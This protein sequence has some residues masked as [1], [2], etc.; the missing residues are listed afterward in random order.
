MLILDYTVHSVIWR[1]WVKYLYQKYSRKHLL[2]HLILYLIILS[3]FSLELKS[4]TTARCRHIRK[5]HK[6]QIWQ[7]IVQEINAKSMYVPYIFLD[8]SFKNALHP[9]SWNMYDIDWKLGTDLIITFRKYLFHPYPYFADVSTFLHI[10]TI[11]QF[12]Y[13]H[14]LKCTNWGTG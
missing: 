4:I 7:R 3:Y 2:I 1:C 12:P 11:L 14:F 6:T 9:N 10:H 13:I 5:S 8:R